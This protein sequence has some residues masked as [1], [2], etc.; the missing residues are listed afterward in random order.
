[1]TAAHGGL[2]LA[3]TNFELTSE[4]YALDA[5]GYGTGA[6]YETELHKVVNERVGYVL[7][8]L[9]QTIESLRE[10]DLYDSYM[11][12]PAWLAILAGSNMIPQYYETKEASWVEDPIY[13]TGWATDNKYSMDLK[14]SNSRLI[15]R[16]VGDVSTLVARTLFYE[17]Y[18]LGH[19]S[20]YLP[21][22][23]PRQA[24]PLVYRS[25]FYCI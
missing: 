4:E 1:M 12:G 5:A 16:S 3:D 11:D 22:S 9:N 24:A 21:L 7:E 15:G 14:L 20:L 6:W 8:K 17:P 25:I 18:T 19:S 10:V 23:R 13:G 2:V